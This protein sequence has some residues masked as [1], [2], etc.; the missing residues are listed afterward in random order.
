MCIRDRKSRARNWRSVSSARLAIKATLKA[1]GVDVSNPVTMFAYEN[2]I[3][4]L[5]WENQ[6]LDADDWDSPQRY[7][8]YWEEQDRVERLAD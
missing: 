3:E 2:A 4:R 6:E 1:H 5:C 8:Y 7:P